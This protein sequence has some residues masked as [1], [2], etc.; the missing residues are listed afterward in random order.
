MAQPPSYNREHNFVLDEAGEINTTRLNAEL[1]KVSLSINKIR[2]NLS[3][4][5]NDD[6]SL[7]AGVVD[8]DTLSRDAIDELTS[9]VSVFVESAREA[10]RSSLEYATDSAGFAKDAEASSEKAKSISNYFEN[11]VKNEAIAQVAVV[12]AEGDKQKERLESIVDFEES[13]VGIRCTETDWTV[14][15][16]SS[17]GAT[18]TLPNNIVYVVGRHHLRVAVNGLTLMKDENFEEVGNPDMESSV[19]KMN[20]PLAVGDQVQVWTVPLGRGG[21][22]DLIERIKI[23]EDSLA[24]LSQTVVYKE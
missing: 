10:A 1:D 16:D 8:F 15:R 4:I 22:D 20:M 17:T 11:T 3:K 21:T 13:A 5:Q 9:A 23:L 18:I 14:S 6:L 7:Q 24:Q 12:A 2:D 19:I